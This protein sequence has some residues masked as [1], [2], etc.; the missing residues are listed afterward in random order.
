MTMTVGNTTTNDYDDM[1]ATADGDTTA[2]VL[3][4]SSPAMACRKEE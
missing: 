4:T 2:T 3:N 1:I